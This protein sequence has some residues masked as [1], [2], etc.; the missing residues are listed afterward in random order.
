MKLK[1]IPCSKLSY[2]IV[3]IYSLTKNERTIRTD[4][5]HKHAVE[6]CRNPESAYTT[7]HKPANQKRTKDF[8]PWYDTYMP[9]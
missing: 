7:C 3:R 5:S 9:K 4:V 1:K 8:G 2:R 6:H